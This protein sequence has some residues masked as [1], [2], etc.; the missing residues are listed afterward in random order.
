MSERLN[1]LLAKRGT[2][3]DQMDNLHTLITVKEAREYTAEE[4]QAFEDLDAEFK[5]IEEAVRALGNASS[6]LRPPTL[7]EKVTGARLDRPA[8]LA[9][10]KVKPGESIRM[11]LY[12]K[13]LSR[14]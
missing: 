14:S 4:K 9:N 1:A 12:S 11:E 8:E 6:L 7:E 2:V 13:S 3:A 10:V 5:K